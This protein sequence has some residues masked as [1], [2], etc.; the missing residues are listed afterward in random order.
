MAAQ[1]ASK[2]R[3]TRFGLVP[4][5]KLE[6]REA[7]WFWFFISPWVIGFILFTAGPIVASAYLSLTN[8]APGKSPEWVG[9]SNYVSLFN[10]RIFWKSLQ[11]TSYDTLLAVP[12]G[13]VL[14][15]LLAV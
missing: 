4:A 14:S 5:G 8:Y 15:L 12:L 1:V 11:V 6:R 3:V 7:L 2:R 10:D 13:I 9:F